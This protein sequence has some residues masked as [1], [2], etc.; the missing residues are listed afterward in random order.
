MRRHYRNHTAPPGGILEASP[1]D[2][3]P[4][5]HKK[6]KGDS[7]DD[8][9]QRHMSYKTTSSHRKNDSTSSTSSFFSSPRS[10]NQSISGEEDDEF[11]HARLPEGAAYQ[12]RRHDSTPTIRSPPSPELRSQP[13]PRSGSTMYG[14][15]NTS[16]PRALAF[17][18]PSSTSPIKPPPQSRESLFT[19][20]K[21]V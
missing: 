20:A 8:L 11:F 9:W 5:L 21:L 15:S 4:G 10:S 19:V 1:V 16:Q 3:E 7:D 18:S 17:L 14:Y 13:V 12:H 2:D 6:F